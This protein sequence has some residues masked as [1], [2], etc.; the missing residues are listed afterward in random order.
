MEN[1]IISHSTD[2]LVQIGYF[3]VDDVIELSFVYGGESFNPLEEAEE[4]DISIL[5]VRKMTSEAH[6]TFDTADTADSAGTSGMANKLV[7]KM[8][9]EHSEDQ[10]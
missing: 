10:K 9:G 1:H 8:E 6:Y 3:E 2:I 4:D 7:L 5:L